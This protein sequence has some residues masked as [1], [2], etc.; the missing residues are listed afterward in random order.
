MKFRTK[1][2]QKFYEDDDARGLNPSHVPR[3]RNILTALSVANT[4]QDMDI[5]GYR[6]HSLTGSLKDTGAYG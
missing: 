3:I 1:S 5:P 4:A 2:L 6:L